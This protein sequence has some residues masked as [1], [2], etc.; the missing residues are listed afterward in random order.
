MNAF[1]K[2]QFKYYTL[3]CMCHRRA[4]NDKIN[5]LHDR[6]LRKIYSD[7][8]RLKRCWKNDGSATE[9]YKIKN[10]LSPLTLT[11]LFEKRNKQHYNLRKTLRSLY[12]Q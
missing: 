4:N 12:P 3:V 5:R 9:M 1:F 7:S 8:H 11:E 10:G 2:S 6:C